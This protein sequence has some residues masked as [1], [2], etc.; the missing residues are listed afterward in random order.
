MK[1]M[2]TIA[3]SV[4]TMG[5]ACAALAQGTI[6][7]GTSASPA[8]VTPSVPKKEEAHPRLYEVQMRIKSQEERI[9]EGVKGNTL[10]NEQAKACRDVIKSAKTQLKANFQTNGEKDLTAEQV[11]A[12]NKLLD[13]N[14][15]IIH[16]E[17]QDS[18]TAT[19][20]APAAH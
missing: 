7:S 4:L 11:A 5:A 18:A 14:S 19:Q 8:S 13:A 9:E 10:T 15:G 20:V 12:L 6:A 3:V 2:M 1:K 16:G 17:K